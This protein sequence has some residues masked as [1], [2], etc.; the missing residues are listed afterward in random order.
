MAAITPGNHLYFYQLLSQEM[1][2]GKQTPL[3]RIEEILAEADVL[4]DDVDCESVDELV[5]ALD[6][7]KLTVFKKGRVFA[8]VMQR[9]DLDEL[10]AKAEQPIIDKAAASSG[11][12]WKRARRTKDVRPTKPRHKRP[13]KAEEAVAEAEV[14]A[15]EVEAV[16]EAPVE[17]EATEV[18]ETIAEAE[19][20]EPVAEAEVEP[21][22]E[23]EVEAT[24]VAV[25]ALEAPEPS[26]SFDIT[27]VPE[28]VEETPAEKDSET[29]PSGPQPLPAP[30]AEAPHP[31]PLAEPEPPCRRASSR[32]PLRAAHLP[33]T[34]SDD[35]F[36]PDEALL[37]LYQA[38]PQK[39]G[40]LET[41]DESWEFAQEANTA[42]GTRTRL[43]FP[44]SRVIEGQMPIEVTIARAPHLPSGKFWKL[45]A[46]DADEQATEPAE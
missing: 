33:R 8:T 1:G 18:E 34:I 35:V 45:V 24:E 42:E 37:R 2:V 5:E 17:V 30:E 43:T 26:I 41:L 28:P 6:F 10:L 11:K 46:V 13:A 39:K 16:A 21:V 29:Q 27:Y 4:L 7:V 22:A 15:A 20:A 36:L 12:S 44:L 14:E 31:E 3:A 9:D 40:L 38:L 32:Q 25:D 19:I 23:A